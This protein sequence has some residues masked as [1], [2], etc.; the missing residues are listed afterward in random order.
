MPSDRIPP[1][2]EQ[3]ERAVLGSILL[4]AGRVIDLCVDRGVSADVFY[5]PHHGTIYSAALDLYQH[6]KV[7]DLLTIQDRLKSSGDL[8]A[9]GGS[10][11]IEQLC[12]AT[13]TPAHAEYY[14][15]IVLEKYAYRMMIDHARGVIDACYAEEDQAEAIR[16]KAEMEFSRIEKRGQL[17]SSK[18]YLDTFLAMCDKARETGCA[19][20]PTGFLML[21]NFLGGLMECAYIVISGEQGTGKTTLA[22]NIAEHVAKQGHAVDVFSMEQP[23]HMIWGAIAAREAKQSLYWL[24]RGHRLKADP[25][26]VREVQADVLKWPIHVDDR[27]HTP[28]TLWSAAR[29]AV[30]K[31]GAK[32][33]IVDYLQAMAPDKKY[34]THELATSAY[35]A[36]CRDIAKYLKVTVIA[37]SS[38]S[39][40]GTT[41]YSGQINYDAW[42]HIRLMKSNCWEPKNQLVDVSF[43]KQ[44]FGPP[45]A[46]EQLLLIGDEQRFEEVKKQR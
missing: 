11:F 5:V 34:E 2:N 21:D 16:G 25:E 1:Y 8:E 45:A 39:N 28:V 42:A 4:D 37:L 44:R 9:T 31:H 40:T 32:L 26:L 17:P 7:V 20:I 19:G 18:E 29:R 3:A 46:D 10:A 14:V 43:E 33:L 12:D 22:R 23:G 38:L 24:S 35:S 15:Q 13:P 6:N 30:S 36:T 27:Q 41:R